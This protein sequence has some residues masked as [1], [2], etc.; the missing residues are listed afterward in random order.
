MRRFANIFLVLFLITAILA[1]VTACARLLLPV[2]FPSLP[3]QLLWTACFLFGFGVYLG[4]GFNRHLPKTILIPLLLWLVWALLDYWPLERALGSDY[5]L[6][7][8]GLIQL[9]LG[10]TL[11]NLNRL[12]N[13]RS[14]LLTSEQ[15]SGPAF[16]LSRLLLFTLINVIVL[17]LLLALVGFSLTAGVIDS[18]TGGFVR[19]KPNGLYMSERIYQHDDKNVHLLGMIHLARSPYYDQLQ[20][21]IPD[22]RT[23]ILLEGVTDRQ[24]LLNERF[25]YAKLAA[26]LGLTPQQQLHF[27]GRLIKRLE[28]DKPFPPEQLKPD[29]LPADVDL[30]AF[31]PETIK[32]LNALA[33][34][35]LNAESPLQGY[36]HF[37]QWAQEHATIDMNRIVMADLISKRNRHLL[38]Y[39]TPALQNYDNLVIPWGALHLKGIEEELLARGFTRQHNRERLSI[40]FLELSYTKIWRRLNAG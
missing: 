30:R 21:A 39:L 29:L 9:I 5:H 7:F 28:P 19:L 32:V 34:Y 35:V 38:S 22:G 14:L 36:L 31:A 3:L 2:A 8:A 6:L 1:I 4:F 16:G 10:L 40:S 20:T 18:A 13:R 17:P 25:N 11:L 12:L 37:N 24:N 15:F 23:L 33:K 27:Q 26:V